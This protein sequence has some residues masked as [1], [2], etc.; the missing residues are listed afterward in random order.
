MLIQSRTGSISVSPYFVALLALC[1]AASDLRRVAL[2]LGFAALH[3]MGHW[4]AL[5]AF[6]RRPRRVCLTVAGL[7]MEMPAES[8]LSYGQETVVAATGP[9]V[10][11][12]LALFFALLQHFFGAVWL[13][14]NGLWLNLGFG[15]FNLLPVCQ[16]DGGR[17]LYA[18]LCRRCSERLARRAVLACSLALLFCAMLLLVLQWLRMGEFSFSL[19]FVVIYLVLCT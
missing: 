10:S 15:C 8:Q 6:G 19:L 7:R 1:A 3:E 13:L 12:L 11:L 9:A 4:A 2:G 18:L 14:E 5:R 17:V 16:L